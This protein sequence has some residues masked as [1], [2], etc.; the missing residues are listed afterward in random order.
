MKWRGSVVLAAAM[1]LVAATRVEG[2]PSPARE[3][4][5][6]ATA[7]IDSGDLDGGDKKFAELLETGRQLNIRRFPLFA[8]SAAS[9]AR[10]AH[11]QGNSELSTWAIGA[12]AK[13]DPLSPNVSFTA[14]DIARE[15]G[16]WGDV[17]KMLLDGIRNVA[18]DYR[19]RT[20][21]KADLL[22]VLVVALAITIAGFALSLFLRYSRSA[23]HDFRELLGDRFGPGATSVL[24]YALLFLPLFFW[25]GPV[26]LVLYWFALL[27]GYGTKLERGAIIVASLILAA[28]PL[29]LDWAAYRI[30]GLSSPV[31]RGSVASIERSYDG[32]AI[33]RLREVAEVVPDNATIQLLLGNLEVQDGNEQQASVHYR[34]ALELNEADAGARLNTGNLFFFNNDFAAAMTQYERAAQLRPS[35][36]I[37]YY[38]QSVTAGELY[39]YDQQGQQLEEAKKRDR[40]LVDRLLSSPPPQKVVRYNLPIPEAWA[41]AESIATQRA[42]REVFGNYARFDLVQSLV[43]PVTIAVPLTLIAA[44]LLLARRGKN[45]AGACIKCGRTFCPRC[46]SSKESAIY[47][48]QCIHIYLKRD[49]VS[50]D[51]K[52]QKVQEVQEFQSANLRTKKLLTAFVPGGGHVFEG[53]TV[54]GMIYLFLFALFVTVA[55]LIGRL[56]PLSFPA[57]TFRLLVRILAITGAVIIWLVVSLPIFRQRQLAQ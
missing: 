48:T 33:R 46:K 10:Q 15:Q 14:A 29:G 18:T 30:A 13:L 47:C 37:A 27:F 17:A 25:L 40:G 12:A 41:L 32:E 22:I 49:G 19:A 36:A 43:N 51:T 28:L 52:R 20:L 53:A 54:R 56:A 9:L 24:G 55:V 39:K 50:V 7:A 2:E 31:V 16:R 5:P 1:L 23:A 57:E 4:W 45:F 6:Q 35:M 8:E 42:S 26:W 34:R 11:K 3:L 38:N 44:F 21:S